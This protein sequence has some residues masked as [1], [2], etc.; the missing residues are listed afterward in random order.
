[1]LSFSLNLRN[2]AK[3]Q[4][5][6]TWVPGMVEPIQNMT[7]LLLGLGHTGQA[8]ERRAKAMGMTTLGAQANRR[9]RRGARRGGIAEV[10]GSGRLH[11]LL[12]CRLAPIRTR[13]GWRQRPRP[14]SK[15][16]RP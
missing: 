14:V 10:M 15:T 3:H 13:S 8:L 16:A 6:R 1:M 5:A 4:R 12:R 7:L 9:C 2:F 11:H